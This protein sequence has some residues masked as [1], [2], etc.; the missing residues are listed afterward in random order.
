MFWGSRSMP[1]DYFP[2]FPN[3]FSA[4]LKKGTDEC[5]RDRHRKLIRISARASLCLRSGTRNSWTESTEG[6]PYFSKRKAFMVAIS[7]LRSTLASDAA[8]AHR[9]LPDLC[10][11]QG[12]VAAGF[13]PG[14][15]DVEEL[16][17]IDRHHRARLDWDRDFSSFRSLPNFSH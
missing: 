11:S 3:R 4:S 17:A 7:V 13:G 9:V 5:R 8:V 1:I 16:S 10:D 12:L 2:E 15:H 14:W 6:G